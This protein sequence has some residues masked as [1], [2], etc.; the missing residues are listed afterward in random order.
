MDIYSENTSWMWGVS[1][2]VLT[3][4]AHVTGVVSLALAMIR[5]R[6]R[7]EVRHLG[8]LYVM[9]TVVGVIAITGLLLTVL[10]TMEAAIWATSY[11]WLGAFDSPSNAILFSL[12]SMTTV[13][14]PGLMLPRPWQVMGVLEA[15]NGALLFGI[16]TA[17]IF[18]VMQVYWPLLRP[19]A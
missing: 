10:H 3:V 5:I 2:I 1:L 8:L 13:G 15:A 4:T 6:L 9:P 18:G 17:Y 12:G 11:L 16:S 7:L 14:A 19:R